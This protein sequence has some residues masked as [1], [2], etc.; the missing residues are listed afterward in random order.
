MTTKKIDWSLFFLRFTQ[1][2]MPISIAL[3]ALTRHHH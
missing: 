2:L 1:A 3:M